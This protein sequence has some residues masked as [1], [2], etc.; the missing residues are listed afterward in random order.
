MSRFRN[1]NSTGLKKATKWGIAGV[2]AAQ[3]A[4]IAAVIAVDEHR[5]RRNPTTGEFPTMEPRSVCVSDSELTV[6]TY[7]EDLYTDMLTAI[8]EARYQIYFEM[9]IFKAD[10]VGYMFREELIAAARRGVSVFLII[11]TFGN[12]N[13]DPRFRFF[14]NHPNLHIIRFP[15]LRLGIFTG[16]GR[17]RGF[18][19]R[20]ILVV[21]STIGFVGGYNI[22]R[23]FAQHWRDTHLRI[24]GPQ[25]WELEN[26][27]VDM[28]SVYRKSHHP[29]LPD[30]GQTRWTSKLRAIQ[31]IPAFK[32]YPVRATYLSAIDR[33]DKKVWITMG[34]FVPDRA[35][36]HA[37]K[38]A[39]HRGVDVRVLLP[40]YSNH[41]VADWVGR[42]HYGDLLHAGVRIFRYEQ[43]MIHA[44]TMTVD[45]IWSTVGT[46][47]ID[48]LSMAG[49]FEVNVEVF[50]H[51]FAALMEEI[52]ALD[53]TNSHELTAEKWDK[54]DRI[55]RITERILRPL[56]PLI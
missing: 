48:R 24:V 21:D 56:A 23:L 3:A 51:N 5:K 27:F 42:P 13:Q 25:V 43:A 53:L 49:N 55:A 22:G 2:L 7:G 39:A 9:Y 28:W 47:N 46:T 16:K 37:L 52:F 14:P 32:S 17:D 41:I 54:R 40:Q 26:A 36:L 34:Y 45:G 12:L 8:R 4:A 44:K 19:H 31:N 50:D 30:R 38:K 6:Y 33:A 29:M 20:K 15:L 10:D 1:M 18:D 11:D 35:I